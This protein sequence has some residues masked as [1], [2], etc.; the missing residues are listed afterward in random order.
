M[1]VTT[2][3]ST[4][5]YS[6]DSSRWSE[7]IEDSERHLVMVARILNYQ[8]GRGRDSIHGAGKCLATVSTSPVWNVMSGSV[9]VGGANIHGMDVPLDAEDPQLICEPQGTPSGKR[10]EF[11]DCPRSQAS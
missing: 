11:K 8:V 5:M 9:S 4:A 10:A 3:S 2:E 7:I 1:A 6:P